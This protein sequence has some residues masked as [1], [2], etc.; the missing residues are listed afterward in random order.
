MNEREHETRQD[1]QV[2]IDEWCYQNGETFK[3]DFAEQWIKED[4]EVFLILTESRDKAI[5][6][7]STLRVDFDSDYAEYLQTLAKQELFGE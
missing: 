5:R 2:L 7:L 1:Q 3:Q 6:T 4:R